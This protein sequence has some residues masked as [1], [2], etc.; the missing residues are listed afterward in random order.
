MDDSRLDENVDLQRCEP[1]QMG[2]TNLQLHYH[3]PSAVR[4]RVPQGG[5]FPSLGSVFLVSI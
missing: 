3:R 1:S 5:W 4:F 2:G